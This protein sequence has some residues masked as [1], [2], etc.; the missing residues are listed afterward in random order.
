MNHHSISRFEEPSW[1]LVSS[2]NHQYH[3]NQVQNPSSRHVASPTTPQRSLLAFAPPDTPLGVA[4]DTSS[5][6]VSSNVAT[7]TS[8]SPVEAE[9]A[10]PLDTKSEPTTT[11]KSLNTE[12]PLVFGSSTNLIT[13][14][15]PISNSLTNEVEGNIFG[16][17]SAPRIQNLRWVIVLKE[18]EEGG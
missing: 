9:P 6:V 7:F 2:Q 5:V 12:T 13:I 4:D 14:S 8:T 11:T 15:T 18:P 16:S 10:T 1:V 3:I 17:T